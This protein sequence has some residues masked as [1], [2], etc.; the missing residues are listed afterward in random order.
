M[1]KK[2]CNPSLTRNSSKFNSSTFSN[3]EQPLPIEDSCPTCGSASL[4]TGAGLKPGQMSLKCSECKG[5][6]GYK[7]LEKLKGLR[8]QKKLTACLELLEKQGVVGDAAIFVLSLA[9]GAE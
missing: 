7:N 1:I 3:N 6:I 8:R 4:V 2:T 5:F 9:G